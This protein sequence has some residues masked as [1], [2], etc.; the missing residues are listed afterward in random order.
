M[1]HRVTLTHPIMVV[2]LGL[3]PITQSVLGRRET[4]AFAFQLPPATNLTRP[5][6]VVLL[7]RTIDGSAQ[8]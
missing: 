6:R 1:T 4:A 7:L 2:S 3:S 8:L 5:Y